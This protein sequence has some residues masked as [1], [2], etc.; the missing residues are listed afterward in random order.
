[1]SFTIDHKPGIY[2]ISNGIYLLLGPGYDV[3]HISWIRYISRERQ[4]KDR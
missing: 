2:D 3:S 1:M 4:I